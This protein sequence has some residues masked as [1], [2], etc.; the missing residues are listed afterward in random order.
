M[1]QTFYSS[2]LA[3]VAGYNTETLYNAIASA[4]GAFYKFTMSNGVTTFTFRDQAL[5]AGTT[6]ALL[7]YLANSWTPSGGGN[8]PQISLL[9]T[10]YDYPDDAINLRYSMQQLMAGVQAM[11]RGC[12]DYNNQSLADTVITAIPISTG[13]V[14]YWLSSATYYAAS[15]GMYYYYYMT[16][17][18][19]IV[20]SGPAGIGLSGLVIPAPSPSLSFQPLQFQINSR[21]LV[22]AGGQPGVT[23]GGMVGVV[24]VGGVM[25][26]AGNPSCVSV[27]E[28]AESNVGLVADPETD[29]Q[30]GQAFYTAVG[31]TF[32]VRGDY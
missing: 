14:Y 21:R 3:F 29:L 9:L 16:A 10:Y 13:I 25:M 1:A 17:I 8:A 4:D 30:D 22:T 6:P 19:G 20:P 5:S 31:R 28:T 23:G 26:R 18:A 7:V 27:G 2:W 12:L 24:D 32:T 15:E 11:Q